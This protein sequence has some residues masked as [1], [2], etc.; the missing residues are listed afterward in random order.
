MF[1]LVASDWVGSIAGESC[2]GS[3]S[4]QRARQRRARPSQLVPGAA[5]RVRT[6]PTSGAEPE[7]CRPGHAHRSADAGHSAHDACECSAVQCCAVLCSAVRAG[8]YDHIY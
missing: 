2:S 7:G 4:H 3:T 8:P 6:Q 5:D 1:F